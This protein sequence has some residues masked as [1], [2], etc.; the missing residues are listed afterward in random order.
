M[1]QTHEQPWSKW[2]AICTSQTFHDP[3]VADGVGYKLGTLS[4]D[5][6]GGGSENIIKKNEFASFQTLSHK[7]GTAEFVK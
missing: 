4:N 5:D 6:D 7:F 3:K 1:F 2:K